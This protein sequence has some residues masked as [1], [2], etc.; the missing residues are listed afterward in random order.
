[1]T[2]EHLETTA[3]KTGLLE[4]LAALLGEAV[5]EAG[6][7]SLVADGSLRVEVVGNAWRP[8]I[9]QGVITKALGSTPRVSLDANMAVAE[10]A[11]IAAVVSA[12][13]SGPGDE[14]DQQIPKHHL[15]KLVRGDDA[16][17]TASKP[18][19]VERDSAFEQV[20]K[21]EGALRAADEIHAA[22]V[23]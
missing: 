20:L 13:Q 7:G 2:R 19:P 14:E 16:C 18:E 23:S 15:V 1:M 12:V 10:G 9:V 6:C 8:P 17:D 3:L 11:A 5:E 22:R 4:P 21:T